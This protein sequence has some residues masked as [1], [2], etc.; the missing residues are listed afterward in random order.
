MEDND[1]LDAAPVIEDID[2][3]LKAQ[4]KKYIILFVILNIV[5]VP[6]A[7]IFLQSQYEGTYAHRVFEIM[8]GLLL[9]FPVIGF[10]GGF[11][12]A[13]IP[14]KGLSYDK[15]YLRA[16]LIL[17]LILTGIMTIMLLLIAANYL[18]RR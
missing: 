4:R 6:M 11:L 13:L 16:S 5:N 2:S 17:T 3:L 8:E 10:I 18:I 12:A 9:G 14:Y 7:I 15:K 1:I